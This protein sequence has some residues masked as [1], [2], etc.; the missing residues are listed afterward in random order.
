MEQR[1]DIGATI[2]AE[3]LARLASAG[4]TIIIER[5]GEE[6]ARLVSASTGVL[7]I[8]QRQLGLGRG[9]FRVADDFDELPEDLLAAF[10]GEEI[11]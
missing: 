9:L 8:R 2:S 7:P 10:E 5:A 6:V 3:R 4:E 1:I 11:D